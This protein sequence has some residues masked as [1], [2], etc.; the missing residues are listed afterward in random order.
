MPFTTT[1]LNT[2]GNALSLQMRD[3]L[4]AA[5]TASGKY[6][7]VTDAYVTS[8]R[9]YDVWQNDG[10]T[11]G[12]IWYLVVGW[13]T[14]NTGRIGLGGFLEYDATTKIAKKALRGTST[15]GFTDSNG[16]PLVS[17]G[18]AEMT[19]A[20]GSF[21]PASTLT[22]GTIGPINSWA[23][24]AVS[25]GIFRVLVTGQIAWIWWGTTSTAVNME[26]VGTYQLLSNAT[27]T[28][29]KPLARQLHVGTGTDGGT[30]WQ[31]PNS[32]GTNYM[33]STYGSMLAG[34]ALSTTTPTYSF[35]TGAVGAPDLNFGVPV[36]TRVLLFRSSSA[37][38]S[39]TGLVLGLSPAEFLLFDRT[40][41]VMV[42][43]T[44]VV[45]GKTY[46]SV[47]NP[48]TVMGLF[49]NTQPAV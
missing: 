37:T 1:T 3:A 26:G 8:T 27:P 42:G 24:T 35:R 11:D 25:G 21:I 39:Q 4:S 38:P 18:G 17:A 49:V 7:K 31:H 14:A 9:Y 36:G 5:L 28:D 20:L 2:T 15:A 13:D 46:M 43:D 44:I 45:D 19:F 22:L 48:G 47:S 12:Y 10:T 23:P 6:T 16:Y 40:S 29:P 33:R 34:Y 30:V 41:S 32:T